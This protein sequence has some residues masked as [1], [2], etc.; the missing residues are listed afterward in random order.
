VYFVLDLFGLPIDPLLLIIAFSEVFFVFNLNRFT[1][2]EED[3]LNIPQRIDFV[4]KYGLGLIFFSSFLCILLLIILLSTNINVFLFV[5]GVI[6]AGSGYSILRFKKIFLFKNIFVAVIWG[7]LPLIVGLYYNCFTLSLVA[8]S[9]FFSLQFF[10]NTVI[11]DIKDIDGDKIHK[12]KTMPNTL[13]IKKTKL[14]CYLINIFLVIF[15]GVGIIQGVLPYESIILI[16][17]IAYVFLYLYLENK[18]TK[19]LYYGVLVDGEFIFLLIL[20]FL[21]GLLW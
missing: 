9:V 12:I 19:N 10:I 21:K 15:L 4:S 16:F 6:L 14:I 5:F 2:K 13:G 8:L 18:L 11:F 20:I 7:T 17:F 3:K 1:D